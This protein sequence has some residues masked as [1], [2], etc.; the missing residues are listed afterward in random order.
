MTAQDD[1]AAAAAAD[2]LTYFLATLR[3]RGMAEDGESR[4]AIERR[5]QAERLASALKANL[6]RRK[7]QMRARAADDAESAAPL[8]SSAPSAKNPHD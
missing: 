3:P 6:R 1:R 4:K 8:A 7:E 5:A 2:N